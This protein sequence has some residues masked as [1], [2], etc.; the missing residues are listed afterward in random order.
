VTCPDPVHTKGGHKARPLHRLREIYHGIAAEN[1]QAVAKQFDGTAKQFAETAAIVDP[2]SD[3]SELVGTPEKRQKAW[4]NAA[5]HAN[6][7]SRLIP[8]LA[9]AMTLA[10]SVDVFL[11]DH[12]VVLPLVCDPAA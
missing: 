11:G 2:D 10:S 12:T 7:L 6:E 1:Y 4:I 5:L 8:P 3:G 9:A